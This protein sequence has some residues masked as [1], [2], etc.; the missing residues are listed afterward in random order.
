[1][2]F[3]ERVLAIHGK[4]QQFRKEAEEPAE[5]H[6]QVHVVAKLRRQAVQCLVFFGTGKHIEA[7]LDGRVGRQS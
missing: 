1:M 6:H 5:T 4:Q 7:A 3:M 2:R